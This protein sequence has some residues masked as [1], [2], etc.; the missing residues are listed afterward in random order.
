MLSE[1]TIEKL[2]ERLANRIEQGNTY[3][4]EQIAKSI[5][6]IGSLTPS[7]AQQLAMIMRYG[8]DYDKI[9]RKLA[10]ITKIN[11]KDIYKIFKEV[12][13]QNDF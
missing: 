12:A 11:V 7:K 13:K 6:K 8:G 3:I 2:T 5:N 9:V 1:E 10:K 4:L